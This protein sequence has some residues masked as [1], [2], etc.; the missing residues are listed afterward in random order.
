MDQKPPPADIATRS[1]PLPS[2]D[3]GLKGL[4]EE[5]FFDD[6]HD[7]CND[8][9]AAEKAKPFRRSRLSKF[10]SSVAMG[11]VGAFTFF[12][13]A[14]ID[15]GTEEVDAAGQLINQKGHDAHVAG[16]NATP[17]NH[18]DTAAGYIPPQGHQA[19]VAA[20]VPPPDGKAATQAA[21]SAKAAQ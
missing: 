4:G 10:V 13:T 2:H 8:L 11:V 1:G 7:S 14:N 20:Y 21:T 3:S 12:T 16:Y 9:D 19:D 17:T 18:V 15:E 5:D 6:E